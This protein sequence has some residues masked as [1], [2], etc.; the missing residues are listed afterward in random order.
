MDILIAEDDLISRKL[1]KASL[2]AAN[3]TVTV[4][5]DGAS[6][7]EVLK[8]P[9]APQVA[10]LDWMMPEMSGVD[11][12]RKLREENKEHYVYVI[13]L[14]AKSQMEDIAEGLQVGADD[15]LTKPFK[16]KELHARVDVGVRTVNLQNELEDHIERLKELDR[17][18]SEFLSMV[19]HEL[20][21]PLA[22]MRGGVTL[23]IDEI[24][25]KLNDIQ[26]ELLGD[27]LENIDQLT[28]LITDLLDMSKIEAG[29][30][31][32]RRTSIDLGIVG[33]RSIAN[34][35]IEADKNEITL[36]DELPE[37][38]MPIY[39]DG[40]KIQQIFTN[41][42]SN[43]IRYT[44]ENGNIRVSITEDEKKYICSV[45]DTGVGIS[46]DNMKKLFSKFEQFGRVDGP[47]YKGTG[48]GLAISKEFVEKHGGEIWAESE[49]GKGTIFY[50]SLKKAEVPRVLIVDDEERAVKLLES[51]LENENYQLSEAY[52]GR[53]AFQQAEKNH[54][55]LI[56]LDMMMP[57]MD[58]YEVIKRLKQ[59]SGTKDIPILIVSSS[60][61]DKEQQAIKGLT[62]IPILQ[63]PI[64][65]EELVDKVYDILNESC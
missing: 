51:F 14:T 39:G 1:I 43:A 62:D 60:Q 41:L 58:G 53:D 31:T 59:Q 26:Q 48:L 55:S 35:K 15:Y 7:W 45:K 24:P 50:F 42:I 64:R 23:C 36:I 54:P 2:E 21:T 29:K 6:A 13:L 61:I 38:E 10:I 22:V 27:T 18:K 65:S 57:E 25:G 34:F 4:T 16:S 3:Y 19:S 44:G 33:R 12:I 56:V 52:S 30:I 32:L 11:V 46:K 37:K 20:R 40:D 63:K 28:R 17:L 47:G 8:K 9:D 49:L 5:E